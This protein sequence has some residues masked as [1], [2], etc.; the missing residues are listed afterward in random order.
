MLSVLLSGRTYTN[1]LFCVVDDS[2][3]WT[4]RNIVEVTDIYG[5]HAIPRDA[6]PAEH[7]DTL[8]NEIILD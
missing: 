7:I 3:I 1:K 8:V 4:G 6:W 2:F 5:D